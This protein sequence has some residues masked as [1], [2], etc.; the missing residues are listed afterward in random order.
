MRGLG[1]LLTNELIKIRKQKSLVIAM[2]IVLVLG[3]IVPVATLL[4]QIENGSLHYYTLERER[5]NVAENME[6]IKENTDK[7]GEY[8]AY[9]LASLG[10]QLKKL[11]LF[12]DN[13]VE[14]RDDWRWENMEEQVDELCRS[15]ALLGLYLENYRSFDFLQSN[16]YDIFWKYT[17]E[18]D[19]VSDYS[20]PV[21]FDF[22]VEAELETVR[23]QL[24]EYGNVIKEN[25]TYE[26]HRSVYEG[27]VEKIALLNQYDKEHNKDAIESCEKLLPFYKIMMDRNVDI[28]KSTW[29]NNT[30]DMAADIIE[31]AN[32]TAIV[33]EDE[34]NEDFGEY[35]QNERFK[36]YDK[37]KNAYEYYMAECDK[38]YDILLYSMENEIPVEQALEKSARSNVE[39]QISVFVNF[40]AVFAFVLFGSVMANEFTN[41]TVRLL[42]IRPRKRYKILTSKFLA[43]TVYVSALAAAMLIITV[44][45]NA[46]VYGDVFT[47]YL[48]S[49]GGN[50]I[51][52]PSPVV[53]F[54]DLLLCLIPLLAV[55]SF[56]V[57]LS[58]LTKRSVLAVALP[59]MVY[60][61]SPITNLITSF[62]LNVR[63]VLE[64]SLISHLNMSNY[65]A[66]SLDHV[67]MDDMS[68]VFG[69]IF[70]SYSGSVIPTPFIFSAGVVLAYLAV[71]T[72][73]SYVLFNKTEIKG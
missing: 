35:F 16:F 11:D 36:D 27:T 19:W 57:L 50:V 31:K 26:Y 73:L 71:G 65:L 18:D 13:G 10:A 56:G 38:A 44:L 39:W 58:I 42:L 69:Y 43:C 24:D 23:A 20:E 51:A 32:V 68:M 1:G 25:D 29:E 22:D 8:M 48:Y 41:G 59:L 63:G 34:F 62:V 6:Y 66:N 2:C 17:G 61:S 30:I 15:E 45:V 4:A 37:Y 28:T 60:I 40:V 72:V 14:T 64:F 70:G 33:P 46:F 53:F 52:V 47:P 5:D 9:E 7:Y 3:L 12:V 54:G 55:C 21:V 67:A 49:V